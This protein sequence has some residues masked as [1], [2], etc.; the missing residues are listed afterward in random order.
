MENLR[1]KLTAKSESWETMASNWEISAQE[2]ELDAKRSR[3]L[4][5]HTTFQTKEEFQLEA[6]CQLAEARMYRQLAK[7]ARL[8]A[9]E[10]RGRLL[11]TGQE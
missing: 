3:S 2:C 1:A 10:I 6:E 11:G 5:D 4:A 8:N 9:E 7:L